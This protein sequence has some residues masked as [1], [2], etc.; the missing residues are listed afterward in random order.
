MCLLHSLFCVLFFKFFDFF[1]FSPNKNCIWGVFDLFFDLSHKYLEV[2]KCAYCTPFLV[3]CL[4]DKLSLR[5]NYG[6]DVV[7]RRHSFL[8]TLTTIPSLTRRDVLS[9]ENVQLNQY[10]CSALTNAQCALWIVAFTFFCSSVY[11]TGVYF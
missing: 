10:H 9:K 6:F 2:G 11:D 4:L 1:H 3:F 8:C 5:C 7:F